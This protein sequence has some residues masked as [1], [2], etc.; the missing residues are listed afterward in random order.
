MSTM[1]RFAHRIAAAAVSVVM[2]FCVLVSFPSGTVAEETKD[3]AA[4]AEEVAFL[5]NEERA[6]ADLAPAYPRRA[7]E[8]LHQRYRRY[9]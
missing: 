7:D 8:P 3:F 5:I 6:S 9:P 2:M 4:M 1:K